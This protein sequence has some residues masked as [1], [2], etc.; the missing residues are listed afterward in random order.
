MLLLLSRPLCI[1]AGVDTFFLGHVSNWPTQT[2]LKEAELRQR[3]GNDPM[4][5]EAQRALENTIHQRNI[6]ANLEF[7]HVSGNG[8]VLLSAPSPGSLPVIMIMQI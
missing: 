7:A 8:H 5:V 6:D 3:L 4:D 2:M 1:L